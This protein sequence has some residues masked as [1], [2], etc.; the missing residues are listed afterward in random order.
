[1]HG[2]NNWGRSNDQFYDQKTGLLAGYEF[3]SE[4]RGGPGLTHEI[5]SDYQK[6]DSVLVSMKQVV[7]IK[8]KSGGDWAVLQ[9]TTFSSATFNDVDRAVFTPP[10]SVRDFVLKGK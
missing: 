7:K 4:W 10:Q 8:P 2:I 9:V 5:F 6:I 1:M 3:D